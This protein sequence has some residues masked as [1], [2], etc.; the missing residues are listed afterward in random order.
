[1]SDAISDAI[2]DLIRQCCAFVDFPLLLTNPRS[3]RTYVRHLGSRLDPDTDYA[4]PYRFYVPALD[5]TKG[6]E[7]RTGIARRLTSESRS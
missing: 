3:D 7:L 5:T 1:M 4:V 2:P 6:L